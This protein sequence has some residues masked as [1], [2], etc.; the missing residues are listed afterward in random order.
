MFNTLRARYADKITHFAAGYMVADI[1]MLAVPVLAA[2]LIALSIQVA[3]EIINR[4]REMRESLLDT[5][6]T[7]GGILLAGVLGW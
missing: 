7:L 4:N 6:A 5:A 2:M 3:H 1:L